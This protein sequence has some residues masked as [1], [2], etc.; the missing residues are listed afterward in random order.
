MYDVLALLVV[1]VL[2]WYVLKRYH[3][4]RARAL[5]LEHMEIDGWNRSTLAVRADYWECP[6]CGSALFSEAAL[7]KHQFKLSSACAAFQE[8]ARAAAELERMETIR[9]DAEAAGRWNMS[10]T[11][12]GETFTNDAPAGEIES[13]GD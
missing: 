10:A 13:S 4:H 11:V 5:E 6:H 12:G 3:D 2:A 1:A 9:K 8:Q 7:G